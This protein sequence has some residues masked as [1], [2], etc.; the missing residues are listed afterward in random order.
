VI[1]VTPS[2]ITSSVRRAALAALLVAVALTG[3]GGDDAK[4]GAPVSADRAAAE[5]SETKLGLDRALAR[6]RDGSR[7][8][9]A[10]ELSK[11]R[12]EHFA[13]VE[14]ALREVDRALAGSL[15]AALYAD[16][17]GLIDDG[18]TV[19]RLAEALVDVETDLDEAVVKLRAP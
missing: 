2:A 8:D 19:S 17:P 5:A 11:A 15:H 6:Y 18:E 13:H 1:A 7:S 12:S 10:D 14:P 9:A 16:L 3:C 4:P